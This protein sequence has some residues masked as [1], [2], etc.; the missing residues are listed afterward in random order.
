[1][2]DCMTELMQLN[3]L[4]TLQINQHE[5]YEQLDGPAMDTAK[6]ILGARKAADKTA[7]FEIVIFHWRG[8]E[9]HRIP[10]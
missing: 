4:T 1:M 9:A 3:F 7:K 5:M 8:S 10:V 6:Q 2:A